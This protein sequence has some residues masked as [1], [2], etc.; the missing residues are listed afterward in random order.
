MRVDRKAPQPV[1]YSLLSTPQPTS[2]KKASIDAYSFFS[3]SLL[4]S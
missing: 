3:V 4:P 2:I 1:I